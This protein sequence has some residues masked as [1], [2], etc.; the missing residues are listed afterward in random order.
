[1]SRNTKTQG[2]LFGGGLLLLMFFIVQPIKAVTQ[3]PVFKFK[4][5]ST[6]DGL[7]TNEVNQVY[8]DKDGYIWFA[9]NSGL[10]Q[11]DGYSIR[12][13]KS[14]L[15]TPDVLNNNIIY[16]LQEDDNQH[17]WLGTYNGLNVLDKRTGKIE[18]IVSEGFS[19][20]VISKILITSEKNILLGT[21]GGV[22]QYLPDRNEFIRY[23]S[24]ESVKGS[25]KA[26]I[27]DSQH[28]IWIGTWSDGLY[29]Y[30]PLQ[31]RLYHYPPLEPENGIHCVFE[32][33]KQRIW[34]GTWKNGVY[35]LEN[36]YEMDDLNIRSFIYDKNNPN[37]VGDNY[38][39]DISE[40][41]N[42][43]TI[44]VGT[45][46]GLSVLFDE[47]N[48]KF[49]NYLP[50]NST[51]SV[52]YNVITSILRGRDGLMWLGINGGGV[53]TVITQTPEFGI[54]R[55]GDVSHEFIRNPSVRSI[56]VDQ[57]GLIWIGLGNLGF[58]IYNRLTGKYTYNM[59]SADFAFIGRVPMVN[60][61][62]QLPSTGKIWIGTYDWGLVSYDGSLEAGKRG[63][64]INQDSVSWLSNQCIFSILEDH[65]RNIWF[66]TRNGICFLSPDGSG[67]DLSTLYIDSVS[68]H[69]YSFVTMVEDDLNQLWTGTSNGGI[70][71]L[72]GNP[73]E[74]GDIVLKKYAPE[75]GKLNSVSVSCLFI[76][77]QKRLWAGTDGGGLN[78]YDV[79]K[80]KF[81]PV[82]RLMK[83]PTDVI[84]SIQEDSKG[85]L[86]LGTNIGLLRLHIPD[87]MSEATYR[88]YTTSDGLQDN[89]FFQ[90]A[91]FTDINGEMFFGGYYGYN[92][93]FP[94]R[95]SDNETYPPVVITDIKIFNQSWHLLDTKERAAI[96]EIAPDFTNKIVLNYKRNN[97][98]IE[99]AALGYSNPLQI[100]YAYWL[101]GYD[102][103]WQYADATR[104]Y[105][106]YNNLEP[107]NYIFHLKATN[108]NGS[109]NETDKTLEIIILPPPWKTWWAYLIYF[110]L[111]I[112]LLY[113]VYRFMLYRMSLTNAVNMAALEQA[114]AEEI[115]HS[116]L[117]FFTN[118]THELLTPLT[119]ISASLD[120]LHIQTPENKLQYQVMT[121]NV[122][123]LIRLLQQILEFRKAET[124]NLK[125][126]VSK[127]DLALFIKNNVESFQ[128]LIKKKKLHLSLVCEPDSIPA[129]FDSDKIDKILYNLLSNAA[130]YNEEGGTVVVSLESDTNKNNVVL[131][132]KDDGKGLSAE[133]VRNLFK[134]FY[135]G[136]YRKFKTIGTGIGLSLTKDLAELH[137]GTINVISEPDKGTCFY[138]TIPI[139]RDAYQ[140]D[141]IDDSL[142]VSTDRTEPFFYGQSDD[143]NQDII[144]H[145]KAYTLLIIEDNED[146]LNLLVRLLGV[147]YNLFTAR[148]GK[149]GI[150]QM[151]REPINLVISDIMM[152]EMDGIEFC[153][154]IKNDLET[155]HIPILLVTAK[156]QEEDRVVAYES[157]A[158]GFITKPFSLSVLQ[159]R[160]N[161]LLKA[162]ERNT[163]DFKKQ[164]V[165]E[166]NELDYTSLDESFLQKAIDL[167]TENL[168][169]SDFD[170]Q[171]FIEAM[172][173]SKSTLQRKI[174][175]LTGLNASGFIRN[176]RLKA[177]CRLMETKQHIRISELA[178]AVGFN[179]PKY[180]SVCFKKEFGM[181]PSEY[182][183]QLDKRV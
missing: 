55:L 102:S 68:L 66:G 137:K 15:Y 171:Q 112:S 148:N 61:I 62:Y 170:Q 176:I 177:A 142:I 67:I 74:T 43:G 168:S 149:E 95:M 181:Q 99:Y 28:H 20:R 56:L 158:D 70:L 37:S 35:L 90:S 106:Y 4:H 87:K 145:N 178:Y 2:Y 119:I 153:K 36:P 27:E 105:A 47:V 130:K 111:F 5:I 79:D 59:E 179:D 109:W 167:I 160:V 58:L 180:F 174:K 157:G 72:S 93:F 150:E 144:T 63:R 103:D 39:Y 161:N 10:C 140:D 101:E 32:D 107:G 136:D 75:N 162:R 82:N 159:A 29:R 113:G 129:Y 24:Q 138:M 44:W 11:Y 54:N 16:C 94:D 172:G 49:K 121:K 147:D 65:Q 154:L 71:R 118:V 104:R 182:I 152:P 164:L 165:F 89:M 146:I 80:D 85:N 151:K 125:L 96:S 175:S 155:S 173:T 108:T 123:R 169:N 52:S 134:R 48:G 132:V 38:I 69:S 3:L 110:L 9:T 183:E 30:D 126:K 78:L 57:N 81:V 115:N 34:A 76:D 84:S 25:I 83:L 64:L 53:N 117:Q 139:N 60:T 45:R 40:D 6:Q 77:K 26:L 124:G 92:Y 42:T 50:D 114:K 127:G 91:T 128:P 18:K 156:S 73:K 12:T 135:E 166:A 7:S 98:N 86:W 143:E 21:E 131:K 51:N 1:M 122:N 23:F 116:K 88:L 120:E 41:L 22:F 14:N 46:N 13:I 100:K 141:E 133:A 31:D 163:R 19:D 17:L 8:E 33:S 97:F